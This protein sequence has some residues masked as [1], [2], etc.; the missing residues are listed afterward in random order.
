MRPQRESGKDAMSR[1]DFYEPFFLRWSRKVGGGAKRLLAPEG[2]RRRRWWWER[3]FVPV[4]PPTHL[5]QSEEQIA[6]AL[7]PSTERS[8]QVLAEAREA[9]NEPFERA[10]NVE[11]RATT[12]QG[13]VAIAASFAVAGGGLL[14]D[15]G[16]ITSSDWRIGIG[17]AYVV[18]IVS[19][20]G[21]ALR[22]LRATS[23][24]H[25]WHFP[26]PEG[27]LKR[28]T[29]ERTADEIAQAAELLYCA[30]RNQPIARYKVAQMRAA[31]D[32]FAVALLG[33]I[34]T[35]AL[36]FAY[37]A[38]G[39]HDAPKAAARD[40]PAGDTAASV[41]AAFTGS[42]RV[43][44]AIPP[45]RRDSFCIARY[46][47]RPSRRSRETGPWWTSCHE[48]K[49]L[50]TI[51]RARDRLALPARF[52][53]VR[54]FRVRARIPEGTAGTY[55]AGRVAPQ[56]E[57]ANDRPPCESRRYSGGALQFYFVDPSLPGKWIVERRCTREPEDRP[58]NWSHCEN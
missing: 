55:L 48:A 15:T 13:A 8:E 12:I 2:S 22:A 27:P 20:V 56:C 47:A 46:A 44:H 6:T 23:R 53:R 36:F 11:R 3:L 26:D 17:V 58:S 38:T 50:R 32:W 52:G 30:G 42:V 25:R 57:Y 21:A 35:A 1:P 49:K 33:L 34:L 10:E 18:V 28:A 14:L 16:K 24:I 45:Q 4:D 7:K 37:L 29:K 43:H 40:T 5:R 39:Q 19:L 9:F 41:L 51:A 54:D 31:A